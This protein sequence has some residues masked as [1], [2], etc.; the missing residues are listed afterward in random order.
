MGWRKSVGI[1]LC[2]VVLVLF[3]LNSW[4]VIDDNGGMDAAELFLANRWRPE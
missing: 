2:F 1:G 3:L 4:S